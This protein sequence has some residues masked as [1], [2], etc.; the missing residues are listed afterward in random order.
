M[1]L[2]G[3]EGDALL[4]L[5]FDMALEGAIRRS[6]VQRNSMALSS[7]GRVSQATTNALV[8]LLGLEGLLYG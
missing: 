4:N 1:T 3:L 2:D 8:R 5:P 6:D 7:H